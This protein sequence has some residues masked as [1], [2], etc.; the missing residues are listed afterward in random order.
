MTIATAGNAIDFGSL[1]NP[2]DQFGATSD[3][4]GGRG[5]Y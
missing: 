4:H 2:K 1:N 3:C 5:G